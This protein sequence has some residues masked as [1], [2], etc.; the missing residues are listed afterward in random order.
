MSKQVTTAPTIRSGVL[1]L[2]GFGLRL[3]VERGHLIVE[4]GIAKDRRRGR[5]PRVGSGIQ[6]VIVL[7]HSGTV[8]LE[9]LRWLHEIGAAFVQIGANGELIATGAPHALTDVRLRRAQAIA[10]VTGVG[11]DIARSLLRDKLA[12][13]TRVLDAIGGHRVVRETLASASDH[14]EASPTIDDLR[15]VESRAAAAYWSAWEPIVIHFAGRDAKHVPTHWRTFGTRRSLLTSGPRKATNPANALLNY[16]YTIVMV[17]AR[18]AALAVGCDPALG[19][20]HSDKPSRDSLA[21]D[22]MEPVR[23][24]VDAYVLH[25]LETH[26]FDRSD[27]FETRDGNCR[28][29]PEIAAPLAT[30]ALKWRRAIAPIAEN[31]G[32]ALQC[33]DTSFHRAAERNAASERTSMRRFRTP[34]TG[35]N[36]SR[37]K[38]AKAASVAAVHL[39][40][41]CRDCGAALS[42][43]MRTYCDACLPEA[44]KRA[45]AK[46]VE[47]Q[48]L[49]HAVGADGRQSET[50]RAAR[51]ASAR[52]HAQ[53]QREWE[54][55]Q[56]TLPTPALF[57]KDV[58]PLFRE[59]PDAVL[60]KASGLSIAAIKATRRGRMRPH[61]RHW[62]ILRKAATEHLAQH[63][64]LPDAL[65]DPKFFDRQIAPHLAAIGARGIEVATSLSRSYARRVLHG[66]HVPHQRHW[67]ALARAIDEALRA[68]RSD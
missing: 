13:Q 49:L 29:M 4:D 18:L 56:R 44:A 47:T 61:A 3:A 30:T 5:F 46:G 58:L 41:R 37:P 66:H 35:R 8:S 65:R 20:I 62:D 36:Q 6:R 26:T 67:P 32:G 52:Q 1:C 45:S 31:V 2:Y 63:P 68:K 54:S 38:T 60:S 15:F 39:A 48:R 21:C 7:G 14:L 16:L 59:V 10:G 50:V 42:K 40:R 33:S 19:V 43:T 17:E 9:A 53:A 51:R 27:F 28:L 34:L 24:I 11:L 57:D 25:F 22:L 23:P 12:G 55:Q 64:P